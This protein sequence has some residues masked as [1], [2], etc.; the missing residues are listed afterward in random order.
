MISI[1]LLVVY[2]VVASPQIN[3][4]LTDW[5][6]KK[7]DLPHDCLH[8][9]VAIKSDNVQEIISYCMNEWPSKWQMIN[10]HFDQ[11]FTF[12]E[13]HKKNV[14]SEQ[15]YR[16]SGPMDVIENYQWY[17]NQISI[18]NVPSA[19]ETQVFYNCTLPRFGPQCQYSLDAHASHHSSL[20][21]IIRDYYLQASEPKTLT[22]YTHLQ[23]KHG[24]TTACLDWS[25][26]CDGKVDCT[27]GLDEKNCFSLTRNECTDDEYRCDNGQC[28]PKTFVNDGLNNFDCLDRSDEVRDRLKHSEYV[29]G[30]PTFIKEDV[31]CSWHDTLRK[32]YMRA[33]PTNSCVH[34]RYPLIGQSM[35]TD[36]SEPANNSCLLA[37]K[38]CHGILEYDD[39]LC[40]D[41]KSRALCRETMNNS[42]P[43]RLFM[44]TGPI[45]Y[46]HI[47][48]VFTK[49]YLLNWRGVSSI[50]P[51]YIC[52]DEQLCGE[53]LSN[54]AS[55]FINGTA[56]ARLKDFSINFP[57]IR[58]SS[59]LYY[60]WPLYLA[61]AKCNTIVYEKSVVC[62]SSHVYQCKNSFKC[63]PK[64]YID[65]GVADCDYGDDEEQTTIDE[66]CLTDQ[67]NLFFRCP[68]TNH[69]INRNRVENGRC[70]CE[71][72]E[73]GV[74]DDENR[75]SNEIKRT[76]TFSTVC[77]GFDD[78]LPIA[79]DGRNET[80]E[81]NC[82]QWP[83]NN[84]N[85]RCD[86]YWNCP[87]GADEINCNPKVFI[88]CPPH[89]HV[90]VSKETNEL[91][92][93]PIE[94][95]NDGI[96]DCLGG[97]DEPK[98][99]PVTHLGYKEKEFYCPSKSENSCV[100]WR[101]LCDDIADCD[102]GEDEQFCGNTNGINEY[103][104]IQ[105]QPRSIRPIRI[106]HDRF[107][108]I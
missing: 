23:C 51:E 36:T 11:I 7:T 76:I 37:F 56:C 97:I 90:C 8:V 61:F 72:D 64:L 46:G 104:Q 62:N 75:Q 105:Q 82:E 70:D 79:I 20:T 87:D 1:Y 29:H 103:E 92:C 30:E 100:P 27:D 42:C 68:T 5:V 95:A 31:I 45:A 52:Y 16:W 53:S 14:T 93:L 74:C 91:M 81:T 80:D 26:I 58:T 86:G 77:D 60:I 6:D 73:Y 71:E 38:C 57:N 13:L 50:A 89:H 78:L 24:T 108:T 28:I 2:L 19:M 107:T 49:Q 99:C 22:C 102:N 106:K 21:E 25:D 32:P 63:I 96:I 12:V 40:S 83:C 3:L 98:M 88:K 85:T 4:D 67:S 39:S 44:P 48:A 41:F 65:D 18:G 34:Q 69:C 35:F 47:Y 54:K 66:V 17:L 43:D 9:A 33:P 59:Y 15:L 94:R 55:M 101:F 84:I 10:N